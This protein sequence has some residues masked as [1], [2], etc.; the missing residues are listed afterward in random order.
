MNKPDPWLWS[1]PL[2]SAT[3]RFEGRGLHGEFQSV[4]HF[5]YHCGRREE[6]YILLAQQIPSM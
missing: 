1:F 3:A 5:Q 2:H 6:R 4:D